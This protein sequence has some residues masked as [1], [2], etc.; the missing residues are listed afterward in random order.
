MMVLFYE[1]P[2]LWRSHF[3]ILLFYE[4]LI[5]WW[6]YFMKVSFYDDGLILWRS[7]FMKVSFYDDGLILWRSCFMK[8]SFYDGLILWRS[9]FMIMVLFYE[10]LILWQNVTHQPFWTTMGSFWEGTKTWRSKTQGN[11]TFS[12]KPQSNS[13]PPGTYWKSISCPWGNV[14]YQSQDLI[15]DRL[16]RICLFLPHIVFTATQERQ[17]QKMSSSAGNNNGGKGALTQTWWYHMSHVSHCIQRW[18]RRVTH[19][20]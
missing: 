8:V 1:D 13:P 19:A 12:W 16:E 14:F 17:C 6:S 18:P 3:M 20:N 15:I 9:H 2:I 4:D 10:G 7:C 5:L 11:L